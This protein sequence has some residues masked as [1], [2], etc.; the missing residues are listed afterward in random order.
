MPRRRDVVVSGLVRKGFEQSDGDHIFLFYRGLDGR[1]TAIR[2]KL[3]RG[4]SHRGVSDVILSQMAKQLRLTNKS[5]LAL[6]DCSLD[7]AGYEQ[8]LAGAR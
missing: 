4:S 6:V 8:I 1:K 5:L 2:T 7:Q 3:S